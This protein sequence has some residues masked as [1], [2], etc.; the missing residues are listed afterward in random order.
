[1]KSLLTAALCL[2]AAPLLA[3]GGAVATSAPYFAQLDTQTE[4]RAVTAINGLTGLTY[5]VGETIT[6]SGPGGEATLV[7]DT[8]AAGTCDTWRPAAGGVYTFANSKQGEAEFSVR[9]SLFGTQGEGTSASPAVVMDDTEVSDLVSLGTASSGW[10]FTIGGS[11]TLAGLACPEGFIVVPRGDD[12]YRLD[13]APVGGL[14]TYSLAMS[15]LID[16]V[17]EGPDRKAKSY[18]NIPP[19]AYTGDGWEWNGAA[20]S[21]LTFTSPDGISSAVPCTG[22]GVLPYSLR[23][24]GT[25]TVEL[26]YDT[27]HLVSTIHISQGTVIIIF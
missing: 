19:F 11:A 22:T 9:Y 21:T 18:Y 7:A 20:N 17:A 25:W 2:S 5:G 26:D 1:M 10:C 4:M 13:D 3:D 16:T 24:S 27:T 23:K 15:A 6:V 12:V 14:A 8:T